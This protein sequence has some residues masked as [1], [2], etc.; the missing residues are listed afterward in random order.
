MAAYNAKTMKRAFLIPVLALAFSA[1]GGDDKE[2][3]KD[4]EGNDNQSSEVDLTGTIEYHLNANGTDIKLFVPEEVSSSGATIPP[5]DSVIIDGIQW[6]VAVGP[7][8]SLYVEEADGAGDYI[9]REKERMEGTRIYDM[10]YMIDEK[11]LIYYSASLINGAGV[12]PFYHVFGVVKID[13][14][15]YILKS[16]EQG[17]FNEG[18]SKKMLTTI[19][20]LMKN[21]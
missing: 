7:K 12:K 18:Q 6:R 21:A 14:R 15:D 2:K 3:G 1:C 19:Q 5:T 9:K 16:F 13:G 17:E 4:G 20:A 8:Y 11:D 10:K